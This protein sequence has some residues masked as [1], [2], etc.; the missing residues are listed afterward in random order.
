MSSIKSSQDIKMKCYKICAKMHQSTDKSPTPT[1]LST[2]KEASIT[3]TITSSPK[4]FCTYPTVKYFPSTR[5]SGLENVTLSVKQLMFT[6]KE[7]NQ[8]IPKI[9]SM[10]SKGK[11]TKS[12]LKSTIPKFKGQP[13]KTKEVVTEPLSRVSMTISLNVRDK[14]KFKRLAQP[15]EIKEWVALVSIIT[16]KWVLLIKQIPMII[17][18]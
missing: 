5:S 2:F 6:P 4:D 13:K 15:R 18:I 12:N 10:C 9:T 14:T 8:F 16:R 3:N 7:N 17:D 1:S 11:Q